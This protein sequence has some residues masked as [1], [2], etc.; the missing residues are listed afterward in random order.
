MDYLTLQ[1]WKEEKQAEVTQTEWSDTTRGKLQ[2]EIDTDRNDTVQKVTQTETFSVRLF[3]LSS[4]SDTQKT[5][6]ILVYKP[7]C[8][9]KTV[10]T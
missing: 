7:L 3:G 9:R 4:V 2:T 5:E 8:N 10:K 6:E 1:R